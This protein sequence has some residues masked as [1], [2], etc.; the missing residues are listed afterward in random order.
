MV[1]V[2]QITLYIIIGVMR[3]V[4]NH[5]EY[6]KSRWRNIY[7]GFDDSNFYHAIR[8]RLRVDYID[9]TRKRCNS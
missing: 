2:L 8:N 5:V 1:V 7:E 3:K 9:Y 6:L 4:K